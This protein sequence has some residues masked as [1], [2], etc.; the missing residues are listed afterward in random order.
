MAIT[1]THLGAVTRSKV[2]TTS[3][4]GW[5]GAALP[6]RTAVS[7]LSTFLTRATPRG[8]SRGR[9]RLLELELEMGGEEVLSADD[10]A[11]WMGTS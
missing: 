7:P 10:M 4:A 11:E 6:S 5:P 1:Q 9:L 3:G 2:N 8:G